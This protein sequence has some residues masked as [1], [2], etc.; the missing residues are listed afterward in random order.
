[1]TFSPIL[2][3]D[4]L[5][6]PNCASYLISCLLPTPIHYKTSKIL[7]VERSQNGP[8]SKSG[9]GIQ[10][11]HQPPRHRLG[12]RVTAPP[13]P[14]FALHSAMEIRQGSNPPCAPLL[15]AGTHM[16]RGQRVKSRHDHPGCSIVPFCSP[17]AGVGFC[18]LWR[19]KFCTDK[20][21]ALCAV[22]GRSC[23]WGF[24]SGKVVSLIWIA[25]ASLE[26]ATI[27]AVRAFLPFALI[28]L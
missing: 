25:S 2:L 28:T 14:P 11:L 7:P 4:P 20:C 12:P 26:R 16:L 24:D 17:L 10:L 18:W 8:S 13:K 5:F 21:V 22:G 6:L 15:Y 9:L 3:W 23:L 27:L 1:M 19:S